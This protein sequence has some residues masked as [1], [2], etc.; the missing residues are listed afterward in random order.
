MKRNMVIFFVITLLLATSALA[1]D[2]DG[3]AGCNDSDCSSNP[4]CQVA[5]AHEA[6]NN[7]C[8]G[9]VSLTELIDYMDEWKLGQHTFTEVMGAIV[10]WKG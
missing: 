10:A 2:C 9:T 5:C 3:Q 1:E 7:P 6:D 4:S 8:D